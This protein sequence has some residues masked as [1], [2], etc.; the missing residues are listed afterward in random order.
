MRKKLFIALLLLSPILFW[1]GNRLLQIAIGNDNQESTKYE[2]VGALL[3]GYASS[4][5]GYG[6]Y[7]EK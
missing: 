3:C 2:I 6:I 7:I 5:G 1:G 4:L